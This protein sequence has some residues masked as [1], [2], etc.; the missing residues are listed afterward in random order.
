MKRKTLKGISA[1]ALSVVLA[2]SVSAT[3][4]AADTTIGNDG[5]A[6]EGNTLIIKKGITLY[7]DEAGEYYSP[8]VQYSYT[9]VP[10]EP[11]SG[12][13]V[14]DSNNQHSI[15]VLK[16]IDNS[17]TVTQPK[18]ESTLTSGINSTGKEIKA[19]IK[20]TVDINAFN[21][22]AGV[23]RY[24]ITDNTSIETLKSAGIV[25]PEGYA[26]TRYLD[27]YVDNDGT[28]LKVSGYVLYKE[29]VKETD[30]T[31]KSGGFDFDSEGT[32]GGSGTELNSDTYTTYNVTL[33]KKVEGTAG[34]KTNEFAFVI[35][36]INN[37][38]NYTWS[39]NDG[40]TFTDS[41]SQPL[42]TTGLKH[43]D[44]IRI[45]GLSPLA[46][47]SYTETNNT[48]DTYKVTVTGNDNVTLVSQADVIANTT[49]KLEAKAIT[50]YSTINTNATASLNKGSFA[51]SVK[52]VTFT[53]KLDQVSPTGVI[54]RYAP[55]VLIFGFGV[56]FVIV[57]RKTK[58]EKEETNEI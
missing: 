27:V 3:A 16:G 44:V 4:F 9:V 56:F 24:L 53:N 42:T 6:G 29:N 55:F 52:D 40:A 20:L 45:R 34:D 10:A 15:T 35:T 57:S 41:K 32:I 18:F 5:T 1:L 28:G 50:D 58:K 11:E 39:K 43:N 2:L 8:N 26:K 7:N 54:L 23:Y 46:T 30:S 47:V 12:T 19:D 22:K 31:K 49:T 48:T 14:T 37:S 33:T 25:R 36:I 38:L 21:G 51:N 13:T 17:I